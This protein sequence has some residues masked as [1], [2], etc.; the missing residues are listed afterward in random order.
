MNVTLARQIQRFI[1]SPELRAACLP[2]A[3]FEID[4]L[5]REFSAF[6]H[7]SR[8]EFESWQ[9]AWNAWTGAGP[10]RPGL[11]RLTQRCRRCRGKGIDMRRHM[12]CVDCMGRRRTK[13]TVHTR[14]LQKV[15]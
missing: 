4:E 8:D 13:V 7:G 14:Y 5:R 1:T 10:T 15:P 6:V 2:P 12:V 11:F 9:D 3:D